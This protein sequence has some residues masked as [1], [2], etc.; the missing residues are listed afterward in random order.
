LWSATSG[1]YKDTG[2]F[3]AFLGGNVRLLSECPDGQRH[4]LSNNPSSTSQTKPQDIRQA[5]PFN[6]S[7][8]NNSARIYGVPPPSG[9]GGMVGSAGGTLASRGP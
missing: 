4:L 8:A 7:N 1:V 3:V 9:A 2:G 6:T 5:V